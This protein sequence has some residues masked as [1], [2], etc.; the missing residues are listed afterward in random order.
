MI[1]I[2]ETA[3]SFIKKI[4]EKWGQCV[5][6]AVAT[7]TAIA[8][9]ICL[10]FSGTTIS[11]NVIYDGKV[12]A[13]VSEK[14]VY[15]EAM[16]KAAKVITGIDEGENLLSMAQIKPVLSVKSDFNTEAELTQIILDNSDKIS[17]GY[18]VEVDGKQVLYLS[19]NK[20][21]N[22]ALE[23][24]LN[25]YNAADK[26]CSSSF[27]SDV[28]VI[29]AY[30]EKKSLNTQD[31]MSAYIDTLDV[32][33]IVKEVE[34]KKLPFDTVVKKSSSK[35]AG[36]TTVT[37]KGVE[38]VKEISKQLT[39]LNGKV[40]EEKIVSEQV[41]S[42]PVNEVV[43]VGTATASKGSSNKYLSSGSF[44][45]PAD[46][47]AYLTVTSYWGDGRNHKAVDIAGAVGT[48]IYSSLA[49]T[50]TYSGYMS[51]YGYNVVVDHGDG[52][53][54]RYAHCSKLYV[55]A[56][57]KVTAGQTIALM[58][59][60]GKSTGSHLHFEVILNGTRVDPAPYIGLY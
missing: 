48:K 35:Q 19:D 20:E 56:G 15:N 8:I 24:R 17:K 32:V 31:E 13:Q 25:M 7:T 59:N 3:L 23:N 29:S 36:Y 49:G 44:V 5:V 60:T 46:K 38:G 57:E 34:S 42:N 1:V 18:I 10:L 2:K 50:V 58:G 41:V 47:E 9:L 37:T 28:S 30:F 11:Y 43:V 16:L 27:T 22:E 52:I 6:T 53:Q 12:V 39:Y 21:V 45:Y 54:T 14:A 55:K 4:N 33:T 40:T 51:D 26:S